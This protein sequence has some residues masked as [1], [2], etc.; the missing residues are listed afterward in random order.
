M[1]EMHAYASVV[2]SVPVYVVLCVLTAGQH[3]ACL[4]LLPL[5]HLHCIA[6]MHTQATAQP[7]AKLQTLGLLCIPP[8]PQSLPC[9]VEPALE[10]L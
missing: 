1:Y 5:Y 8:P 9:C 2:V 3:A 4:A 6:A 7:P 10:P